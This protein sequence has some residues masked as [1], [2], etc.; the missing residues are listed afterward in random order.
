VFGI[1]FGTRLSRVSVVNPNTK[2]P[3]VIV[4]KQDNGSTVWHNIV[5]KDPQTDQLVV[6]AKAR[7]IVC[8]A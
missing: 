8:L 5:A 1:D 2:R 6:G 3:A 4:N 7:E